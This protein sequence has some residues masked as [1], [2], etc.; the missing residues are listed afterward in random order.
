MQLLRILLLVPVVLAAACLAEDSSGAEAAPGP[1]QM[2]QR[3]L[4]VVM[5]MRQQVQ[6]WVE[7]H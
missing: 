5:R 6:T 2:L 4:M 1:D 3:H 7:R